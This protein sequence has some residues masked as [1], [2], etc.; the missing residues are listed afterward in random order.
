MPSPDRAPELVSTLPDPPL[1]REARRII[2]QAAPRS[3]L[4]HSIRT[5][6]LGRAYGQAHGIECD[7]EGLLLAALF[8]DLGLC[9]DRR[10]PRLP[11][12]IVGSRALRAFLGERGVAP[13]RIEPMVDAID[14]HM[15]LRPRWSKGTTVGLLQVGAWMDITGLRRRGVRAAARAIEAAYPRDDIRFRFYGLLLRSFGSAGACLGVV[16]PGRYRR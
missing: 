12:Q 15:Q 3:L 13:D 1:V 8:H 5:F 7:E 16:F 10:D 2:E 11:F 14:F 9:G 4:D 6:L